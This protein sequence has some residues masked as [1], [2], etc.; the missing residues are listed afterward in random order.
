MVTAEGARELPAT[1]TGLRTLR[2]LVPDFRGLPPA[3]WV[4][5]AG[6]LV[7]RVGGFVF[8]FLAI[9]LTE[10]RGLNAAQAGAVISAYGVGA[11]AGGAF[12]G[13]LSDRIGRRPILA[14]SLIGGG[15]SMLLLGLLGST[16]AITVIAL[17]TGVLYE[18]YR[19]V[20]SATIAGVGT[21]EE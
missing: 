7:N 12:G 11:M 18:M 6:T 14:L 9:Y 20:V 5:F 1:S 13:A 16:P 4:L 8:V 17:L 19:P 2:R 21:A 10:V 15:S 3:F